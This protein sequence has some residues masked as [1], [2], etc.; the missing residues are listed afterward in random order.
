[1]GNQRHHLHFLLLAI[2]FPAGLL[3][4]GAEATAEGPREIVGR[5]L[6]PPAFP[7]PGRLWAIWSGHGRPPAQGR[8]SGP[9]KCV[10]KVGL[11]QSLH[12]YHRSQEPL[13]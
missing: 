12:K 13:E 9:P 11:L 3:A 4:A 1:M 2:T 5:L 7:G 8:N 10:R 6:P